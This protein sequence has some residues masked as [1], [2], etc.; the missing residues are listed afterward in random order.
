M[1]RWVHP[2]HDTEAMVQ[3]LITAHAMA[4]QITEKQWIR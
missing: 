4:Q 1:H 3:T 2:G